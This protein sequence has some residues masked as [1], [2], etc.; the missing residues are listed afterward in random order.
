M[1]KMETGAKTFRWPEKNDFV[2]KAR[3]DPHAS[4]QVKI[5]ITNYRKKHYVI[6]EKLI[7]KQIQLRLTRKPQRYKVHGTYNY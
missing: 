2:R 3:I 5:Q 6:L 7:G 4:H 1:T